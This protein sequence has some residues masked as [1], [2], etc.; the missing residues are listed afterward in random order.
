MMAVV[1][2]MITFII[3]F[4]ILAS[5]STVKCEEGRV[6]RMQGDFPSCVCRPDCD[7]NLRRRGRLCASD[8]LMYKNMCTLQK[9]NCVAQRNVQIEYFGKCHCK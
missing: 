9:M 3:I 6:C 1:V 2:G 8:G 5:C 4:L 7:Q